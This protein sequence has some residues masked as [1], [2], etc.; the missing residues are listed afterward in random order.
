MKRRGSE[1]SPGEIY[2]QDLG[3]CGR[4]WVR[5]RHEQE[6]SGPGGVQEKQASTQHLEHQYEALRCVGV[7][8]SFNILPQVQHS[9]EQLLERQQGQQVVQ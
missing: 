5:R 7:G 4:Q 2:E 8:I 9:L 6:E 1:A 3:G